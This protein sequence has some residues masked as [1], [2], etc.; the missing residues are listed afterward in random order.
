MNRLINN[1]KTTV[2]LEFKKAEEAYKHAKKSALEIAASA[3]ASP[4]QAGDRFH[5]QGA[6]DLAKERFETFKLLLN[7]IEEK[8]EKIYFKYEGKDLFLV[9]NPVLIKGFNLVS[10]KSPLG[11]K[12]LGK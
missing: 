5:S 12:I 10:V 9:E 8:G 11:S 1:L 6:A 4:S 3:A 7:E 2:N